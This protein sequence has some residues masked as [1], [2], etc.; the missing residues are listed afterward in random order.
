M[1]NSFNEQYLQALKE[2][3]PS[4]EEQLVHTFA[5]P[6]KSALRRRLRSSETVDDAS[7]ETFL[8]VLKHF[9]QGKSL[10][11][12]ESLPAFVSSVSIN[13]SLELLRVNTHCEQLHEN[14]PDPADHRANPERATLIRERER[15]IH[16]TLS[17]LTRK[18]QRVLRR[19]FLEEVDKDQV[20]DELHTNRSH[21][22]VALHRARRRF[23]TIA[24]N[25]GWS[26]GF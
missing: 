24:Q 11:S 20:C 22:R 9:R 13:V 2:H 25:S 10:Q 4:A 14:A 18:D 5:E 1:N 8:R 19:V 21:L 16:S 3:D 23:K 17:K 15:I 12:P 7:Q 6:V 26:F